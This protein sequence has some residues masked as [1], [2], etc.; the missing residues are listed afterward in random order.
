MIKYTLHKISE[1]FIIT[2]DEEIKE[3]DYVLVQSKWIQKCEIVHDF[4]AIN[5]DWN[6]EIGFCTIAGTQCKKI[7]ATDTSLKIEGIPQF[8]L[9]EA[10]RPIYKLANIHWKNYHRAHSL[11]DNPVSDEI[12]KPYVEFYKAAQSGCFTEEKC[13]GI[14]NLLKNLPKGQDE[15]EAVR[16]F[17]KQPKQLVAIEVEEEP[18]DVIGCRRAVMSEERGIVITKIEKK[19]GMFCYY[20]GK[21]QEVLSSEFGPSNFMLIDTCGKFNIGDSIRL[22]KK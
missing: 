1:G 16:K 17:L 15:E 3:K 22:I 19:D 4:D 11:G 5:I 2:S 7:I 6:F 20:Y 14:I 13:L 9:E 21:G 12:L 18:L 10:D 8:K